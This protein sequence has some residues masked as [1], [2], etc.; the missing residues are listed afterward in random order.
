MGEI[1]CGEVAVYS[2]LGVSHREE[3]EM[4]IV[5]KSYDF[6]R[7][8]IL[9]DL[10][11]AADFRSAKR[12]LLGSGAY[13]GEEKALLGRVSLRVH[14]NDGMYIRSA[15]Q[16]YLSV[17]LSAVRAIEDLSAQADRGR[18]V[19][20]L[21]DFPCGYGRVLRFL[22]VRF[23]AAEVTAAEVDPVALEFCRRTFSGKSLLS[24]IDFKNLAPSDTFD[25]IWCGSLITHI[26]EK[27]TA[28]LL[29]FFYDHLSPGGLCIFTTHG[30]L[31]AELIRK[32][33][34]TYGLTESAQRQ[35]L[36]Q[37]HEQSYGYADYNPRAGYGISVVSHERMLAIA[38]SVGQ[39]HEA[40]YL[41]HGWDHHQDVY[42]FAMPTPNEALQPMA[43]RR[44]LKA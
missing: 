19:R 37:F 12:Q 23:P 5:R 41:E 27:A 38:C 32:K 14:P 20:T 34:Q 44:G 25:L 42:G 28:D 15:A 4:K 43:N 24:T 1:Y 33:T 9:D 40:G 31:S 8:R 11:R 6:L 7:H 18:D 13:S 21:L 17:G 22:R 36:S 35:V 26:E 39:W 30:Q 3:E 16:H 10:Y 29:R 2:G